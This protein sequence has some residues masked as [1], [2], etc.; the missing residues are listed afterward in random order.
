MHCINI[1]FDTSDDLDPD[2][3]RQLCSTHRVLQVLLSWQN[4]CLTYT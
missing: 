4:V 2:M 1:L 3:A